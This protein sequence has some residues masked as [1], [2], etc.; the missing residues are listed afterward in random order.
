MKVSEYEFYRMPWDLID[1]K[2]E[3]VTIINYGKYAFPVS[4]GI[5]V[6]AA[7]EGEQAMYINGT[8]RR[9]YVRMASA[10]NW[11]QWGGGGTGFTGTTHWIHDDDEDT[12]VDTEKSGTGDADRILGAAGGTEIFSADSAMFAVNDGI[13]LGLESNSG[14]TYMVWNSANTYLETWVDGTKRLEM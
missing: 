1:F 6:H 3:V 5:P 8:D 2:D 12:Y 7:G 11:V 10:W 4:N 13:R 14:D 9:F